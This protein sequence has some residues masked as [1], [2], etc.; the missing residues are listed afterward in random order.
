MLITDD[1]DQAAGLRELFSDAQPPAVHALSCPSRPAMVLPL[2]QISAHAMVAQGLTVAWVDEVDLDEREDWPVPCPV[3]FDLA[4]VLAGHVPLADGLQALNPQFW[5]ALS[6]RSQR[7]PLKG[8]ASLV[9]RLQGSGL[10]FDAVVISLGAQ[11]AHALS[12][13]HHKVHHTVL[14]PTKPEDLHATLDWMVRL[15]TAQP[16]ASWNLV[17]MSSTESRMAF[18]WLDQAARPLLGQPLRLMGHVVSDAPATQL[19][20][21][22]A[23]PHELRD[24]LQKHLR[25][26]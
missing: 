15:H 26:R 22:W 17:F 24:M 9:K 6:R 14:S 23:E 4:Q 11:S 19:S 3:R 18:D 13:Y 2:V 5:Y 21:V 25:T 16:V 10:K 20:S 1:K 7:L 8:T 12:M